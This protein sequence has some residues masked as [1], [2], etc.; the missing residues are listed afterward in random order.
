LWKQKGEIM[1]IK[2]TQKI[3]EEER[4]NENEQLILLKFFEE[5][6]PDEQSEKYFREWAKRLYNGTAIAHA[7]LYSKSILNKLGVQ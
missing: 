4:L 5:R 2:N 1:K 7:D 6:F 3:M